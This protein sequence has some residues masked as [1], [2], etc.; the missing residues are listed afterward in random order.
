MFNP[1][2][3]DLVNQFVYFSNFAKQAIPSR[4]TSVVCAGQVKM[5]ES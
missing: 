5:E 2:S 3:V 4:E 1:L